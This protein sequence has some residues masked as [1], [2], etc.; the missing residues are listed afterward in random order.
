[1]RVIAGIARGRRLFSPPDRSVRPTADRVKEALFS[2]VT[3]LYGSLEGMT[4]LDLFA[5][6][7]S[8]GI[9]ALSRGAAEAVFVEKSP[10]AARIIER[11]LALTGF[12][13]K[14]TIV[15][16][17]FPSCLELLRETGKTFSLVLA[18]PPYAGDGLEEIPLRLIE[19]SL[20]A[21]DATIVVEHAARRCLPTLADH[22]IVYSRRIYG[23]TGLGIY[24][25]PSTA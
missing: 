15:R 8:L 12:M 13:E 1:M 23:D 4:V 21:E 10:T 19:S 7:G 18:D 9:E 14:G 11:N 25:L 22:G 3:S 24:R 5:G 6:T 16:Q 2:I 20:L 17:Q